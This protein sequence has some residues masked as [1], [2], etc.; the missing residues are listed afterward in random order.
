MVQAGANNQLGGVKGGFSSAA[1]QVGIA[2]VVNM[3]PMTPAHMQAMILNI[4]LMTS[5]GQ[6]IGYLSST[7]QTGRSISRFSATGLTRVPTATLAFDY[8]GKVV[9][10]QKIDFSVKGHRR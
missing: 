5:L 3:E 9:K 10:E 8:L 1:Y 4:N 6:A 2:G 7:C